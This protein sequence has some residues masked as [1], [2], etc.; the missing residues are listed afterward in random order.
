MLHLG[1]GRYA[2]FLWP[3]YA[4]S[5]IVLAALV[6]ETLISARRWRRRARDDRRRE[7]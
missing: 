7:P 4:L 6:G 1:A 5:A 3:A 2:L